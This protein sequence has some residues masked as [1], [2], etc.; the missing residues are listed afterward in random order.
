MPESGKPERPD[1]PAHVTAPLERQSPERRETIAACTEALADW[2]LAQRA[3]DATATRAAE[4]VDEAVTDDLG[5]QGFETDPDAHEDVPSKAY[6]TIRKI[7]PG[8]H[9]Y[10][11]K[12]YYITGS[13]VRTR[14][15]RTST[16]GH[17]SREQFIDAGRA[18]RRCWRSHAGP[19]RSESRGR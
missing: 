15:G 12:R 13:G 6:I 2:K 9:D 5:G 10:S 17:H 8:S 14:A 1:L 7:K 16:V 19:F 4:T 11:S 3:A 18:R